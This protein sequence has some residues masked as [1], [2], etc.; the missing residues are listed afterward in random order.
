MSKHTACTTSDDECSSKR[1][2]SANDVGNRQTAP[3]PL[4]DQGAWCIFEQFLTTNMT[5]P[6]MEEAFSS[7]LSDQYIADDWKDARDALFSADGDDSI[8]LANI[9]ALKARHMPLPSSS[10]RMNSRLL[11]T[12]SRTDSSNHIKQSRKQLKSNLYIITE[13][14]EKEEEEG[15]E[16]DEEDEEG[17]SM[18]LPTVTHL[19]GPSAKDRL[20][21]AFNNIYDRIQENPPSSSEG[22]HAHHCKAASFPQAIEGNGTDYIAKHLQSQGLLVI[23]FS[24]VA[25]Q[26][27]NVKRLKTHAPNFLTQEIVASPHTDDI[28]LHMQSGWDTPFVRKSLLAFLMQLLRTGNEVRVIAGE[29]CS[30]TGTVVLMDH[31][32]GSM[33]L[34]IIFN[35]HGREIDVQLEDLEHIFRVGPYLGLEGHIIQISDDMFHVCQAVSKEE[36]LLRSLPLAS[37]LSPAA[38]QQ[39]RFEPLPQ[40]KS[41]Q[42]GDHI[43]VLA[44][45][46]WKKCGIVEWFPMGS[47]MLW[48]RDTDPML[49]GDD[50]GTSIRPFR[51]QV[52]VAVVQ[53]TKLPDTLKYTQE[54]GYNVR[55][56][57]VVSVARG[58][59]YQRKGVVQNID[60]PNACLTF[61]S[62][63]DHSLINVPI[64]FMIKEVFIV[65]GDRKGYQ[66]TL[67]SIASDTCTVAVHGQ[68][69]TAC[70]FLATKLLMTLSYEMR[71]N[72]VILEG[73]DLISFCKMWKS[74]HEALPPPPP[75]QLLASSSISA[76][77]SLLSWASWTTNPEIPAH[78]ESSSIIPSSSTLDPWAVNPLDTQDD[79]DA[80]A[81]KVT[82]SGPL[83][84]LM[85]KEYSS[86]LLLHHAVLK[87][88]LVL[89]P[90]AVRMDPHLRIVSLYSAHPVMQGPHF[91]TIT[92]PPS[93]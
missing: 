71:L 33:R 28:K 86:M 91:N 72:G 78:D 26:K 55:P 36:I 85:G 21:A 81:D 68:V 88:T 3:S 6:Q 15:E 42:V 53:Q 11:S 35:G 89:T 75:V 38:T 50:V 47:A 66:A 64:R 76:V 62:D 2:Q 13:A 51:I 19:S 83:P 45:E 7:Y 9:H 48:F 65:G 49:A 79:T 23:V 63:S 22:H 25:G 74:F 27:K 5:Y 92:F 80:R 54:R 30:K 73:S 32:S 57:D 31:A 17:P 59:E 58:S 61:L 90:S 46:H 29:I 44:G 41:I 40:S 37:R 69:G 1:V 12:P 8:A 4:T 70:I 20:A 52:P 82:D 84:W 39:Q 24:W 16:E 93:I 14:D 77:S 34:E 67:Y 43:E 56:G 60:F 87:V 10:S 18:R